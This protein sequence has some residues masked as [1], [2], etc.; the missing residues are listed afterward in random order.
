MSTSPE[1]ARRAESDFHP[2]TEGRDIPQDRHNHRAPR[3]SAV[4]GDDS[5][6]VDR[7]TVVQREKESYGGVKWGSAFFG[8]LTA[9]GTAVV[10]TALLAGAGAAVGVATDTSPGEATNQA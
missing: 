1:P 2:V 4:A 6:A 5:A 10:L 8:W 3:P 7:H 9:V